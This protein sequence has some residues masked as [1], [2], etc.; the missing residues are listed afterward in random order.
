[1][2]IPFAFWS[3]SVA[4]SP[5]VSGVSYGVVD[6]AGG[7]QRVVVTV[8]DSTGCTSISA[9]AVAFTSFA[10]DDATHVSGIPG[11]HAAGVVDV[12]VTNAVGD[13]SGGEGLIEYWSPLQITG[14]TRYWDSSLGVTS[15]PAISSWVDQVSAD[16]MAQAVAL[17]RPELVASVFGSLPGARFTA[18]DQFLFGTGET[19]FVGYSVFFVVK[20]VSADTSAT[21]WV[22]APLTVLGGGGWSGFGMSAGNPATKVYDRAIQVFSP[23]G[24]NDGAAHIVGLTSD[25]AVGAPSKQGY[26]DGVAVGAPNASVGTQVDYYNK[27]GGYNSGDSIIGDIGAIVVGTG[28][29][30]SGSDRLALTEWSRQR[31]GVA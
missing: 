23:G 31:F 22:N 30:F 25:G 5:V 16:D 3:T 11:A 4:S 17:K 26:V 27:I 19:A 10:I 7:G 6:L 12:V 13:S 9:G 1:M 18:G 28:L 14:V 2:R 20:T 29:I 24:A 15:A 8:N 21:E